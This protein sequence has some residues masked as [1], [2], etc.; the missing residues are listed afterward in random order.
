MQ[1]ILISLTQMSLYRPLNIWQNV[2]FWRQENDTVDNLNEQLLAS[3]N[4]EGF[5]S[6]SDDKVVDDGDAETYAMEYL[7]TI[8][9]SNLPLHK[10][11]LKIGAPV[12]LLCNLNPSAV[13]RISQKVIECEKLGGKHAGNMVVIPWIPLS[14]SSTA[15]LPF[16]FRRTQLP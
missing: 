3:M 6:Y 1:S 11:K 7:N 13:A 10:L 14:P 8:N 15:D 5:T 4:G 9:L 12:I 16:E 2:R